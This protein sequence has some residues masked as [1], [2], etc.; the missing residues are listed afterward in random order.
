MQLGLP[1]RVLLH[2]PPFEGEWLLL[3][4][5]VW[6]V[7]ACVC[8]VCCRQQQAR[9]KCNSNARPNRAV[10]GGCNLASTSQSPTPQPPLQLSL[11]VLTFCCSFKFG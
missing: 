10:K 9:S 2:V 1:A 5:L 8:F 6:L 4:L 7:V 3:L 11:T